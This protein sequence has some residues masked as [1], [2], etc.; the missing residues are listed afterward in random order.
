MTVQ[1]LHKTQITFPA[2]LPTI[3]VGNDLLQLV[4]C[5]TPCNWVFV[6]TELMYLRLKIT[7]LVPYS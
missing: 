4:D 3:A 5:S 2:S 1:R 6:L 7:N